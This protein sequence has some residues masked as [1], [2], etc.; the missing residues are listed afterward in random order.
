MSGLIKIP[1]FLMF[2]VLSACAT[3]GPEHDLFSD[4]SWSQRREFLQGLQDWQLNGR[5]AITSA[6]GSG[7]LNLFWQQAAAGYD[8]RLMSFLGQQVADIRGDASGSVSLF[9][10]GQAVVRTK[11]SLALMQD[12]LGWYIPL[13]GLRYWVLGVP[14]PGTDVREILADQGRLL[15]L[16]QDGWLVEYTDYQ[17]VAGVYLPRKIR[18][19][20]PMLSARMVLDRWQMSL[21]DVDPVKAVQ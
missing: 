3:Y 8:I 5:V 21:P 11:N 2:V 20:H 12:E 17:W 13:S 14:A 9:R 7:K 19:T 15:S 6:E 16:E 10:P 18:L 4:G 1:V